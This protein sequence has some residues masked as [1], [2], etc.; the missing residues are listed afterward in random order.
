MKKIGIYK[1]TNPKNEIYVGQ[2]TDI[3]NRWISIRSRLGKNQR[4]LN[5]SLL[6]YGLINHKFEIIN[7]CEESDLNY[8]EKYYIKL[9]DSIKCGL[10]I[11]KGGERQFKIFYSE[12][13]KTKISQSLIKNTHALGKKKK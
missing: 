1:I 7:E 3:F 6:K 13:V 2:S 9:Y 12:Q 4:K 10:N 5:D 8:F 11:Q